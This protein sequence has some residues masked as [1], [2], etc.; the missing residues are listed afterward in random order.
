[1]E[2]VEIGESFKYN[3]K[4]YY[5]MNASDFGADCFGNPFE[6]CKYCHLQDKNQSY[7]KLCLYGDCKCGSCHS[8]SRQDS[9]NVV[10]R[11]SLEIPKEVLEEVER[12]ELQRK[13]NRLLEEN[14]QLKEQNKRFTVQIGKLNEK[15]YTLEKNNKNIYAR[16]NRA[17]KR[18]IYGTNNQ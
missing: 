1:M 17:I 13:Y 3:G 9:K 12:T 6:K 15:V 10:F 11:N 4:R 16:I 5:A 2:N 18:E 14:H 8:H 7:H